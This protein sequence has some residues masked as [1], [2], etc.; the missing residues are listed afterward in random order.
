MKYKGYELLKAIAENKM[1]KIPSS[2]VIFA[3]QWVNNRLFQ[4]N[5][6]QTKDIN[7]YQFISLPIAALFLPS[8]ISK[9]FSFKYIENGQTVLGENISFAFEFF[10][11]RYFHT[12]N[13][14]NK[15]SNNAVSYTTKI[16][17]YNLTSKRLFKTHH[18]Y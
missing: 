13:T 4:Y 11:A 7:H 18:R 14:S 16:Y 15:W 9:G 2:T 17:I 10:P 6:D 12:D 3:K 5:N 1:Y 8:N